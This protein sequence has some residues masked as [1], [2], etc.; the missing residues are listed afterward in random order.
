MK[1]ALVD[2]IRTEPYPTLRGV[3]CSCSEEMIAK[4]GQYKTWHWAHK[5][6]VRCDPWHEPETDWHG[7]WKNFF[8]LDQQEV[9]HYDDVTN[10]KHIAD[11]KTTAGL[12]IEI[13][14]SPISNQELQSRETFYDN[15]IWIVDAREQSGY[16]YLGTSM[17][18]A[19]C[20]PM[21]YHFQWI[22][23]ST[24]IDRWALADKPVYFDIHD[25][26]ETVVYQEKPDEQHVLWRLFHFN[27]ET[28]LGFIAPIAS[29]WLLEAAS[30]GNPTPL[31]QCE[32]EDAWRYRRE[33]VEV[34]KLNR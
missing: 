6:T 21:A 28:K 25:Q 14:H 4:C 15:M 8:P 9:I 26:K 30:N 17:D 18:L 34:T 23:R 13:Q 31:M 12:V 3:C 33:L 24:L 5:T 29:T 10:E 2:G 7:M 32:E 20:D 22:G 11:V 27:L 1:F 19:S 16:F